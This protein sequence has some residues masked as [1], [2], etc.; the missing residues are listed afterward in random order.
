MQKYAKKTA[1]RLDGV[2]ISLGYAK[3]SVKHT[4]KSQI[5]DFLTI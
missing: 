4:D 2:Q 1:L 3:E 5:A